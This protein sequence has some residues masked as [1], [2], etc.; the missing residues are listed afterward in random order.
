MTTCLA[1]SSWV[2]QFPMHPDLIETLIPN[3]NEKQGS[4]AHHARNDAGESW[5][6][7]IGR[8]GNPKFGI[9]AKETMY[10]FV[11]DVLDIETVLRIHI[12]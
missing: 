3:V 10:M 8:I 4:A 2:T 9:S 11:V 6:N 5:V 12:P 7:P 1:V